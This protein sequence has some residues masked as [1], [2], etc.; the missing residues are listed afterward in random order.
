MS[1]SSKYGFLLGMVLALSPILGLAEESV[2][3]KGMIVSKDEVTLQWSGGKAP[4]SIQSSVDLS[5]WTS[6]EETSETEISVPRDGDA[7]VFLRVLSSPEEP[8]LG[9][10]LGQLRVDEGEFG[11]RLARH[12]MKSLWD[13]HLPAEGQPSKIPADY[14]K[15]LVVRLTYREG[16]GLETFVGTLSELPGAEVSTKGNEMT[17]SWSFGDGESKRN[18]ELVMEFRYSLSASRGEIHLSDTRYTLSCT[19][20]A[21]QPEVGFSNGGFVIEETKE[22]EVSLYQM[23]EEPAPDWWNR[24]WTI[25]IDGVSVK[26]KFSIGV[27]LLEGGPAFI[28]KTPLLH[29]WEGTTI[30]GLTTTPIEITDRFTQ[31]YDPFHHNFVETLWIEPEIHPTLSE[32]AK[33]ELRDA[34]IR[35]IM[36]TNPTAFPNDKPSLRVVGYDLKLRDL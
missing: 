16:A 26:A 35:V 15:E 30:T 31:T 1:S 21:S 23:S 2:G 4:Y 34:D 9:D 7:T 12:R 19:Y 18:Y 27:P 13:F 6:L 24:S 20:V 36:A 3:V 10:Y 17:V 28:W 29:T 32:D 14:F 25:D 8:V 11:G 33:A 22:D 5:D